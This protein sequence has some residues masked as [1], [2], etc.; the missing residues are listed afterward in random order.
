[1]YMQVKSD[2]E[3]PHDHSMAFISYLNS[4]NLSNQCFHQKITRHSGICQCEQESNQIRSQNPLI[5]W[6]LTWQHI[7]YTCRQPLSLS[8]S[9]STIVHATWS[10]SRHAQNVTYFICRTTQKACKYFAWVFQSNLFCIFEL[11]VQ[12]HSCRFQKKGS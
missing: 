6:Y 2:F 4:Y 8:L 1:M 11:L 7:L 3:N 9:V 5:K 10:R 12:W